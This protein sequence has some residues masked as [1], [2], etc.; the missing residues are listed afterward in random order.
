MLNY[1]SANR[2]TWENL[3]KQGTM[4][5]CD[6]QI[7]SQHI[8]L[9]KEH[10][11]D[12]HYTGTGGM[13]CLSMPTETLSFTIVDWNRYQLYKSEYGKGKPLWVIYSISGTQT[14]YKCFIMQEVKENARAKTVDVRACGFLETLVNR[15]EFVIATKSGGS[16]VKKNFWQNLNAI[17]SQVNP[18]I[19]DDI[20]M[21]NSNNRVKDLLQ[22]Y[23]GYAPLTQW[24]CAEWLQ[25]FAL[26]SASGLY[27]KRF[28]YNKVD[29]VFKYA[30]DMYASQGNF[31]EMNVYDYS[32]EETSI[33]RRASTSTSSTGDTILS[34]ANVQE[35]FEQNYYFSS[36]PQASQ[37]STYELTNKKITIIPAQDITLDYH[38]QNNEQPSSDD[39]ELWCG[40]ILLSQETNADY[41]DEYLSY[42]KIITIEGRIDPMIECC[43]TIKTTLDGVEYKILVEE[44]EVNFNGGFSGSLKGRIIDSLVRPLVKELDTGDDVGDNWSFI[45]YNPNDYAVKMDIA[46]SDTVYDNISIA[47]QGTITIDSTNYPDLNDYF[48]DYTHHQAQDDLIVYFKITGNAS[49]DTI[50]LEAND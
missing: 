34:G 5:A 26:W 35:Y 1:D 18:I 38:S 11:I 30:Y 41:I 7:S 20:L 13:C 16:I 33:P 24:S 12:F 36:I 9:T 39:E 8:L 44:I 48:H 49:K 15:P 17:V 22:M 19:V 37:V 25:Q 2:T 21:Y 31:D 6:I 42:N 28:D 50:I 10:I 27:I 29:L 3:F 45:I 40:N 43:D 32:I 47:S 46:T 14:R 4:Y 23:D